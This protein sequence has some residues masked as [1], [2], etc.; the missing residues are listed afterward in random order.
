[1]VSSLLTKVN[2]KASLLQSFLQCNESLRTNYATLKKIYAMK[3]TQWVMSSQINTMHH[4]Y[5]FLCLKCKDIFTCTQLDFVLHLFSKMMYEIKYFHKCFLLVSNN[6]NFRVPLQGIL[7]Q[8]QGGSYASCDVQ[9]ETTPAC[10]NYIMTEGFSIFLTQYTIIEV[11]K[12]RY[13]SQSLESF[14]ET[15]STSVQSS[16]S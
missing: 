12:Y 1:M 16:P 3:T 14:I 15:S 6:P 4:A 11:V 10:S 9:L 7:K 8:L 5:I 13:L 2:I